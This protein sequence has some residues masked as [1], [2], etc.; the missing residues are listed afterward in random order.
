MLIP[1]AEAR[2]RQYLQFLDP[3]KYERLASLPLET[4]EAEGTHRSPPEGRWTPVTLPHSY[5][6]EW[7]AA[8]FRS[9]FSIPPEA[10]GREVFL[11][12]VPN[13]DSLVF[14][15]GVP[16]GALNP[17]H[18]KMRL[19]ASGES[20]RSYEV[21]L[22]AYAGH[23][24][25]GMHPL[26]PTAVILTLS[27]EVSGY[28]LRFESAELLVRNEPLYGLYYDALVLY[29]LAGQLDDD[30]LRKN[31]ILQGLHSALMGVRL[32]SEG[33][34]LSGQAAEA[35]RRLAP[36][37]AA[38]NGDTVPRVFLAG[39]A[40]IDHAWLWPIAET[41]RKAARTFAAMTRFSEEY[42]EFRFIQ[43]Q[44]AQLDVVRREYPQVFHAVQKAFDRGQWEPNGGMWVEADCN[45]PSGESLVRQ[46]L[47]GKQATR[48]MLG[49]EGDVLWLPDVFGYAAALPQILAGCEIEFFV[50]SKINWNDTTRFPY[51]TFLWRGID[52][53]GVRTH[54]ITSRV[55][56]YNGRVRAENLFDAW[57]QVQHKEV[58]DG[59]I[60][61][62]G[63]G[64]GGGGT[65]RADLE[66]ARRL[67]DLEGAPRTSWTR[68]SDA[69]RRI[70]QDAGELP[71]RSEEHTSEL[72]SP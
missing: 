49:Y 70:F 38:K 71:V 27:K 24:Y 16:A 56:G 28:P 68:V 40:H 17:L 37:L 58:Q 26:Q 6:K 63:E 69:L 62:V 72:Q 44:P 66:S 5:G 1:K 13:A 65:M 54:Y 30:S 41:E 59:L 23:P 19:C 36:L 42:P 33:A 46:F 22:E 18:E 21:H 14:V 50:T 32:S 25:A 20:G 2:I 34:E 61:S 57:R 4:L 43:S 29:E 12:A 45:I 64:D 55:N 39:H 67:S 11:R 9:R 48:E 53:T 8:W 51:D 10:A 31:R 15:D 47:V 3:R 7:T 52:G 60:L 35:R